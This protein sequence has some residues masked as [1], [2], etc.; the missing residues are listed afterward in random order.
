MELLYHYYKKGSVTFDSLT[1]NDDET[2]IQLMKSLY[3]KDSLLWE[4]FA[5]PK[6]YLDARRYTEKWLHDEFAKNGG[7]PKTINPIYFVFGNSIWYEKNETSRI[8]MET[9]IIKIPLEIFS[10]KEISFTYPDSMLTLLLA[11]QKIPQYYLPE[12][13]GKVFC[14]REIKKIINENG[15]PGYEWNPI[16]PEKMPNYI[17]AQV[18]NKNKLLEYIKSI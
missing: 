16:L 3:I 2:A 10:D 11:Y 17:E 9:G 6:Q 8:Q 7:Q 4:R 5:E 13:H 18:W 15:L 12:Y 14:L 1:E